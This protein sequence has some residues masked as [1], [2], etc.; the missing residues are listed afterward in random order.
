MP[1]YRTIERYPRYRFGDDGTIQSNTL[2]GS[3]IGT[4]CEWFDL[5]PGVGNHG[6]PRVGIRSNGK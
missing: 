2:K 6:Y 5:N 1:T 4:E 3:K